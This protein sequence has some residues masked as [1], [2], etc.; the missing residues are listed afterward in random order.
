MLF[1]CPNKKSPK[2]I[3]P[4]RYSSSPQCV[5]HIKVTQDTSPSPCSERHGEY[6][7]GRAKTGRLGQVTTKKNEKPWGKKWVLLDPVMTAG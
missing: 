3:R 6:L 7:F 4:R 2:G 5:K 1:S